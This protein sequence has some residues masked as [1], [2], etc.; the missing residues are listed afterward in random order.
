M[1]RRSRSYSR[2]TKHT[3]RRNLAFPLSHNNSSHLV[4]L[5]DSNYGAC[6]EDLIIATSGLVVSYHLST[7]PQSRD[8][9]ASVKNEEF[10]WNDKRENYVMCK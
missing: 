2:P 10:N 8:L 6:I 7:K 1:S 4:N 9:I 5:I 3:T